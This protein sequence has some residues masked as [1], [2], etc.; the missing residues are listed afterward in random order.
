MKAKNDIN[1]DL[2][3]NI[4]KMTREKEDS[5][6]RIKEQLIKMAIEDHLSETQKSRFHH[7]VLSDVSLL[8]GYALTVL[9]GFLVGLIL[10]V[11]DVNTIKSLAHE[12]IE[13]F[14][15]VLSFY[16]QFPIVNILSLGIGMISLGLLLK[17]RSYKPKKIRDYPLMIL[18]IIQ[19][20][21]MQKNVILEEWNK[22][23]ASFDEWIQKRRR[24][25]RW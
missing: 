14:F 9:S 2:Y 21:Q 23:E 6:E 8:S 1:W 10:G 25:R 11:A 22:Y 7:L 12:P 15:F 19:R 17:F 24:S 4:L 18:P 5:D 3:L 20:R 16:L 13:L